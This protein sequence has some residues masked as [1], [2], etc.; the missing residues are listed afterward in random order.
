VTPRG[1]R[2]FLF[3]AA[4]LPELAA[5]GEATSVEWREALMLRFIEGIRFNPERLASYL[6]RGGD[7]GLLDFAI[8]RLG[9]RSQ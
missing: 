9:G 4:S 7:A 8:E 1:C 6:S 3:D 2:P 5:I